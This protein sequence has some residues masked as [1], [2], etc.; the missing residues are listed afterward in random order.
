VPTIGEDS[1]RGEDA[2]A[3]R[4]I[5]CKAP[6]HKARGVMHGMGGGEGTPNATETGFWQSESIIVPQTACQ[7]QTVGKVGNRCPRDPLQGR[8]DRA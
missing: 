1:R 3:S 6:G 7:R 5:L 8:R 4:T 2:P